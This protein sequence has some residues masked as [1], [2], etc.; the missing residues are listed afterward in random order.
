MSTIKR[1]CAKCNR[2]LGYTEGY[3]VEGVSHGLCVP[4]RDATLREAGLDPLGRCGK[5]A[6]TGLAFT[7]NGAPLD[8]PCPECDG[9][10]ECDV[11][12]TFITEDGEED[13]AHEPA[14]CTNPMCSEPAC[15]ETRKNREI[16]R[17]MDCGD[18]GED[19]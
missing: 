13:M 12:E 16:E 4:C 18:Y 6:G 10:G 15:V 9:T 17:L 2:V 8:V 5:C 7:P 14:T 3:G 1:I 19:R 11:P